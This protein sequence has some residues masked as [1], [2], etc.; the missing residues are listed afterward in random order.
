MQP[1]PAPIPID[2][3]E[4]PRVAPYRHVRER[5]LV[6]RQGLFIAEGQVV[7]RL[8]AR[9]PGMETVSVLLA[10][11]R[12]AALADALAPLDP[13]VPVYAASQ[14]VIDAIAGFPLHR[15]IL[16]LGR[17]RSTPTADALLGA[18]PPRALVVGL[19]GIANHDNMGALFR[20]AAAFGADAALLDST[21]CDPLY[22]KA[23][24]VSVGAALT[25]PFAR[26]AP[27]ADMV[28]AMAA[29]GVTPLALSPAGRTPLTDLRR[30]VRAGLILG[31]EGPGLPE[32]LLARATSVSI[33]MAAGFD[34]LNV[35]VAAGIVLHHLAFAAGTPTP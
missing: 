26:L 28:G 3:P 17:R 23:I 32:D 20:N 19:H 22:R 12:V 13:Q 30:P 7:L 10:E 1:R 15:G 16:A 27:D 11:K 31:A 33:P 21:C 6:G 8:L 35:A 18:L 2:D 34:S 29:H 24:R 14:G 25:T 5:D 4:D 9:A